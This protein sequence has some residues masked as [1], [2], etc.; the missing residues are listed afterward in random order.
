[1]LWPNVKEQMK[2]C[3]RNFAIDFIA[4]NSYIS[5][6]FVA[7]IV[8]QRLPWAKSPVHETKATQIR[9]KYCGKCSIGRSLVHAHL[10]LVFASAPLCL[11]KSICNLL[12]QS[13]FKCLC[14]SFEKL[15]EKKSRC[16]KMEK[17]LYREK[18]WWRTETL[19]NNMKYMIFNK[20][21]VLHWKLGMVWAALAC[22]NKRKAEQQQKEEKYP[23]ETIK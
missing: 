4:T 9:S 12:W 3:Y 6:V 1:M 8:F 17:S 21:I 5:S 7:T 18:R 11:S 14:V 16:I 20:Y 23:P 13:L 10:R 22:F 19:V 2:L 15:H